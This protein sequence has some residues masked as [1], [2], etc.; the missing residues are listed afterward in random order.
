MALATKKGTIIAPAGVGTQT[1]DT[2]LGVEL[3]AIIFFYTHQT[4]EGI[5]SV[6]ARA[7]IEA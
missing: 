7:G 1:Y 4:A 3:K 2:G 5:S 6:A